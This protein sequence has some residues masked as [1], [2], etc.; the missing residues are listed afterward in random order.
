MILLFLCLWTKIA[1]PTKYLCLLCAASH[2]SS[3]FCE[4]ECVHG[5]C[6]A[7]PETESCSEANR[8]E[9]NV[10]TELFF[11]FLHTAGFSVSGITPHQI[12]FNFPASITWVNYKV[13]EVIPNGQQQEVGSYRS[14]KTPTRQTFNVEPGKT[15][16]FQVQAVD[17][18]TG[19]TSPFSNPVNVSVPTGKF[20]KKRQ[21][22]IGMLT[23]D[24]CFP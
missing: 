8:T 10:N 3:T 15:Y 17:R 23:Y 22:C 4:G 9:V 20:A 19:Q 1:K 24:H 18:Y 13:T 21:W 2:A 16:R 6:V 11:F 12:T 7:W 5:R 14:S